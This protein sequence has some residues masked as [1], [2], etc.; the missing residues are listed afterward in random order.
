[1]KLCRYGA[2]GQEVPSIIDADGQ[3]RDLSTCLPQ[4][5][6]QDLGPDGL[7]R[8]ADVDIE[9][10]PLVSGR[11]RMGIPYEGISKIVCIGLN[12]A[13][14][15]AEAGLDVPTEPLIFLKAPTALCGPDDD[16]LRPHGSTKLDW[17]VELAVVI[18][19]TC[20]SVSSEDAPHYIAGYCI[21]ND[22]SERAFQMQSSQWD[23][24]K[25]CDTFAP[26]GPW[27]VTA[28]E[29]DDPQNLGLWL[30]VNGKRMQTGNTSTMV[31]GVYELIAYVSR[32]MTLLPGDVIATG[33]PS[34]VGMGMKPPVWLADEDVV[35]LAIEGLGTQR[36]RILSSQPIAQ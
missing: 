7:A 34:G 16:T 26:L 8:I 36:Q 30:D 10:L 32:Y 20:R 14:H 13:D 29:I 4:L 5:T 18:G 25:G 22:V 1:M 27:L 15:A 2:F 3:L 9:S 11:Y 23:K 33:T 17:E 12:Y 24:G 35:T 21:M 6:A 31:F 19:T 28:D